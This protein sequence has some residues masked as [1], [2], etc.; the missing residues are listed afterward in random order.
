MHVSAGQ[1]MKIGG[2]IIGIGFGKAVKGRR[3]TF[4]DA[5]NRGP[6]SFG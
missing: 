5:G 6:I 3:E 4:L 1:V 2:V